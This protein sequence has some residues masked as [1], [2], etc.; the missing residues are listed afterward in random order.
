MVTIIVF[1]VFFW[2]IAMAEFLTDAE[3]YLNY[4]EAY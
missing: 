2:A 1:N 4:D 3:H